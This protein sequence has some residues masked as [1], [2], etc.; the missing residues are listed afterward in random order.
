MKRLLSWG[1]F[2]KGEN[3]RS[4]GFPGFPVELGGVDSLYAA[5]LNESRTRGPVESS[6]VGNPGTLGMTKVGIV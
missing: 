1:A 4:L 3:C 2:G 5:F 6:V